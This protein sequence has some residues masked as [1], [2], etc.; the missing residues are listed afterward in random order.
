M[1]FRS[2]ADLV[3]I[4]RTRAPELPRD[5]ELVVGVPR[6]GMLPATVIALLLDRPLL[7]LDALIAG[8]MP[9]SGLTRRPEVPFARLADVRRVLVV[10]DSITS[11]QSMARAR[12][13]LRDARPDLDARF[14]AVISD[15]RAH[16]EADLQFDLCPMPRVFE[17]NMMNSWLCG[18]AC[19]DLDGVLCADPTA[20]E[21]DDGPRY[22]RFLAET[23]LL[24][25]PGLP[26]R[27]IVTS[28]LGRYRAETEAWLAR[29][30]ITCERLDMLEGVSA[31]ERREGR[32]HAPFKARVYAS[33]P[34][35]RLF[36]ESDPEQAAEIARLSGKP[37]LDAGSMRL[38][39]PRVPSLPWAA[40][41]VRDLPRRGGIVAELVA[42][43]LGRLFTR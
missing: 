21:N 31:G 19:F 18:E 20:A 43:R 15:R 23:A 41:Q 28:R 2:L 3:E 26:V 24:R 4:T 32:L 34:G 22:R 35:A 5:F 42:G 6:S 14:L 27:R 36:V 7:D 40:A 12:A 9:E 16:P 39:D 17:W 30:S 8:R 10:D 33:D 1:N 29:H 37:V 11:G 25:R 13:R 38:M